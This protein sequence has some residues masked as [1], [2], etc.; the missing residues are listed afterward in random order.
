MHDDNYAVLRT[1]IGFLLN[2][3]LISISFLGHNYKIKLLLSCLIGLC[4]NMVYA[5][6]K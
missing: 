4:N 6:N 3:L 5:H 2:I 1:F